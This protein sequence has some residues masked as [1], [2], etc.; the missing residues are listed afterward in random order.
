MSQGGMTSVRSLVFL[1]GAWM[2]CASSATAA[3]PRR[4]PIEDFCRNPQFGLAK[5]S[6]DGKRI[7]FL[8]PDHEHLNIWVC[9]ADAPFDSA[10]L[11][12]HEMERGI[13]EFQWTR[14]SRWLLYSGDSGGDENYHLFR[15]DP[16]VPEKPAVDLTPGTGAQA[17]VLHLPH[18]LPAKAWIQWNNRDPRIFDLGMIDI[19]NGAF[20]MLVK[21]SGPREDCMLWNSDGR[22]SAYLH[23]AANGKWDVITLNAANRHTPPP[24]SL[25]QSTPPPAG[26]GASPYGDYRA[27]ATYE[28][29][30]CPRLWGFSAD[31]S[32]LFLSSARGSNTERLT[33]LDIETG[34]ETVIDQDP[35][36]NLSKV[37]VSERTH[38][39]L[40][41]AYEKERFEMKAFDP[42]FQRDLNIL[43]KTVGGPIRLR[44]MTEDE[45][46]WIVSADSP[47]DPRTYLYDRASGE[48]KL[49]YRSFP[50]L[51]PEELAEMKPIAFES[52]DGWKIHGY[53]TLPPGVEPRG[54]P[55]VLLVHGGPWA[56]DT[57]GYDP[58]VQ[59]L[60]NRGYAVLQVNFR[61]STGYGARFT[62]AAR[63]EWG[64][65]MTEDLL[66]GAEWILKGGIADPK[67]LGIAGASYGGYAALS[68]LAFHPE[69]F[70][71]G[72]DISGPSNLITFLQNA[73]PSWTPWRN[74]F[75]QA[76]GDPVKEADFVRSRSPFFFA[77]KIKAPLFIA[78]GENDPRVKRSESDQMV[79][80]LRKNGKSVEYLL[81]PDEG[82]GFD[83]P[84]DRLELFQKI[85]AFLQKYLK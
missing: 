59:L 27:V 66:D 74:Q 20:T 35:E 55:T 65:K 6:P 82:H 18:D 22:R 63:R 79:E 21:N 64:G 32:T 13:R 17:T 56:R 4:I 5:I 76:I 42:P 12:T 50:W 28:E 81:I 2:L 24:F 36:Y 37:F 34:E 73:P 9:G 30:D 31:Q 57:W 72:I 11:V 45:Q 62:L 16:S 58:F 10:K 85:E 40:G 1:G 77:N 39:L 23:D 44:D 33:A 47:F 38:Q 48:A 71:C 67:R 14:D 19:T 60:A 25:S 83:M 49:L 43:S 80:A 41:I 3:P 84:Q 78:Q 53:L 26:Q 54:L 52:R 68:A 61:G 46:K 51:K 70:A 7:A 15:A 29:S 69:V 75:A 8:A